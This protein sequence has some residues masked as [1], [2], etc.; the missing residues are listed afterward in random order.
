MYGFSAPAWK[1]TFSILLHL[2]LQSAK[3]SSDV[4]NLA[5]FVIRKYY[6]IRRSVLIVEHGASFS[7]FA[8]GKLSPV[9]SCS[10]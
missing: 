5:F 8:V 4:S 10:F 6:Y 3:G 7:A 9:F 1:C 2:G